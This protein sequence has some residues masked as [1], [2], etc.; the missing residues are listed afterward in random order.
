MRALGTRIDKLRP[1]EIQKPWISVTRMVDEGI[2]RRDNDVTPLTDEDM[3]RLAEQYNLIKII[4][5]TV[6]SSGFHEP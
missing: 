3:T 2:W 1:P 4:V 6:R 5:H